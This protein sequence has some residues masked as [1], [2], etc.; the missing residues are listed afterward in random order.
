MGQEFSLIFIDIDIV[1]VLFKKKYKIWTV[2]LT[3]VRF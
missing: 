3:V 1:I 2:F